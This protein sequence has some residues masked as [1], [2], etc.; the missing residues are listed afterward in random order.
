M[1]TLAEHA[2]VE[3]A[4]LYVIS[5]LRTT[6]AAIQDEADSFDSLNNFYLI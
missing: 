5:A 1:Q 6:P 4:K 2:S 3:A